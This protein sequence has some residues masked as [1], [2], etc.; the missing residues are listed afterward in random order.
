[1]SEH[2]GKG[3]KP[4]FRKTILIGLGGAGQQIVLRTKR[5][6]MDTYGVVPPSVKIFCMDTD[7]E[8][9][10]MR[11]QTRDDTYSIK[12]KEFLHLKVDDPPG[13]IR[14]SETVQG[15][16]VSPV[17]VNA[18]NHGAGAVRQNGRLAFFFWINEI[19]K[20][21]DAMLAELNDVRLPQKMAD[22]GNESGATTGFALSNR[23]TEIYVC[24]SVAGGTGSGTFIDCGLLLRELERNALIH[25]FFLLPWV[26]RSKSFAYRLRQ[27]AYAALA[28]L[29]SLQS[30]MFTGESD[31]GSPPY[32]IHYGDLHVKVEKA[33]YDLFHLIDGRNDYG[34]NIDSV[35][36]LC[37]VVSN[38]IFLSMGSMSI[39]ITSVNDN[40]LAFLNSQD[41]KVW[42]KRYARYSS[43]GISSLHYPAPELHRWVSAS[44][45]L[46]ICSEARRRVESGTEIGAAVPGS[47]ETVQRAVKAVE[48]VITNLNLHRNNIQGHL[49][50]RHS[51]LSFAV[52]SY[53]I[54]DADFAASLKQRLDGEKKTLETG[55]AKEAAN[56][57]SSVFA[58]ETLGNLSAQLRKVESSPELDRTY[59][60]EWGKRLYEHLSALHET[61]ANELVQATETARNLE[62]DAEALFQIAE[63][64]RHIPFIGGHRK[65]A[66]NAWATRVGE[67]LTKLQT[68]RNLERERRLYERLLAAV[69]AAKA[70]AVPATS[71]ILKALLKTETALQQC[72]SGEGK[73][74]E[75]LRNR[76]N[77][78]LLGGGNTI[79]VPYATKDEAGGG[80]Q[81]RG[82]DDAEFGPSYEEF[83]RD[84]E[85]HSS[86]QY[87]DL[88][89]KSPGTLE[90]LFMDYCASR[91]DY[92][93]G[94][95]ADEA[96]ETLANESGDADGFRRMQF[97]HLF[98]LSSPLW[99]FERGRLNAEQEALLDKVINIGFRDHA[100]DLPVYEPAANDAKVRFHI[101]S[102]LAFSTTGDR[103]R[104]WMLCFGAA[105]PAY[106]LNGMAEAKRLYEEQITPTYHIDSRLEKD[107]P[108][109]L[110]EGDNANTA[111]RLLGMAIVPGIDVIH[112][113]KLS[114]GHR[115]TFDN[116]AVR[117][118]NYGEPLEWK[119]FRDMYKDFQDNADGL[120]DLLRERLIE[121][122][123]SMD[124]DELRKAIED[125]VAKLK[126]KLD[127]R[128]FS[129]LVSARLTYREI[130]A[131]EHFLNPRRFAMK[132]DRYIS[133]T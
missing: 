119:L 102:Q 100:R 36:D 59:R 9:L 61:V 64:S 56:G 87:L 113:E 30:I 109:L 20:R 79:I 124:R 111:L 96:L 125:H 129:R 88:F 66:V 24:G 99:S 69:E 42:K 52:E 84:K 130:Q 121:K 10:K 90:S 86:E 55:L 45:A 21:I 128:D 112:D 51:A 75:G 93:L 131:L 27:N 47:E 12:P 7:D 62:A 68:V 108:D 49:C 60:R 101:D 78:V 15:W 38:A 2:S 82:S 25:G 17:P 14:A 98:R 32:E 80:R 106:Y 58:D 118:L 107:V 29:D 65:S 41:P 48:Q 123:Q 70:T 3:T 122:V 117:K 91:L 133:G 120:L 114:K 72:V 26:Y 77:H 92:I 8:A 95:S 18:I 67:Y 57:P 13:F 46:A 50:P 34:Q 105:L 83:I 43:L 89:R 39:P 71:D 53:E 76:P 81:I 5:F 40:L 19:R 104:L 97:D 37:E 31:E 126:A 110:P 33:P 23:P 16:Y 85:I 22:A 115:F 116:D 103:H 73:V 44:R 6:F 28:E 1:M 4:E 63:K 54:A 94:V 132:M 127:H 11:S 35:S 74:L